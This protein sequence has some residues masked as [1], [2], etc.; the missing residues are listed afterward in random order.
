MVEYLVVGIGGFIGS[1][2]RFGITRLFNNLDMS[3]P[4]GT[5]I[6]NAIA[7]L[8][9]G[10]IIGADQ[11]YVLPSPKTRLFLTT[12]LLGGLSTFSTFSLETVVFWRDGNYLYATLNILLNLS[13]SLSGV[14]LGMFVANKIFNRT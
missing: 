11:Q 1:C 10:F 7:G 4:F 13:L 9:I 2:L 8:I 12:G 3:F 6:S 5:L 14:V